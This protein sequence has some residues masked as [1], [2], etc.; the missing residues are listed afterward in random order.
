LCIFVALL[1]RVNDPDEPQKGTDAFVNP[2]VHF[3]G[4]TSPRERSR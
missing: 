4:P 1:L 2:F 3:C